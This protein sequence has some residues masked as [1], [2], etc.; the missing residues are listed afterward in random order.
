MDFQQAV[1]KGAGFYLVIA[2]WVMAAW[3]VTWVR[4]YLSIFPLEI[5]VNSQR[6]VSTALRPLNDLTGRPHTHPFVL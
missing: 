4:L 3:A 5:F 1:I 6:L 2:N